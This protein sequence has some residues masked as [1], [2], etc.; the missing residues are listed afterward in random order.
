MKALAKPAWGSVSTEH[1]LRRVHARPGRQALPDAKRIRV[2]LD[3]LSVIVAVKQQR[4]QFN[5]KPPADS[6][7]AKGMSGVA[8]CS[9][10]TSFAMMLA[11]SRP[12]KEVLRGSTVRHHHALILCCSST[13][14]ISR[15]TSAG[16]AEWLHSSLFFLSHWRT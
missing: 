13:R 6:R 8:I 4:L 11:R 12:L 9:S 10:P 7:L 15:F 16:S 14:S 3:N 1:R 2:V 5:L